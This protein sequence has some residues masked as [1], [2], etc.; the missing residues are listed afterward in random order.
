MK[1]VSIIKKIN[2]I[3]KSSHTCAKFLEIYNVYTWWFNVFLRNLYRFI[4]KK[5]QFN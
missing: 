3:L 5:L 1:Y 2:I 4:S